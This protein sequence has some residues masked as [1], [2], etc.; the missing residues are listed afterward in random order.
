MAEEY[1]VKVVAPE[2]QQAFARRRTKRGGSRLMIYVR[3]VRFDANQ[4]GWPDFAQSML[5]S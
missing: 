3:P 5:N 1:H 2:R 4:D